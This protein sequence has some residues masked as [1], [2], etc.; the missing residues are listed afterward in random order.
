MGAPKVTVEVVRERLK[1][2]HGEQLSFDE[3]TFKG[4]AKPCLFIDHEYGEW[5]ALPSN[6]F[7]G[8]GHPMRGAKSVSQKIKKVRGL[9]LEELQK[10]LDK[11]QLDL[12]I[13]SE[14]FDGSNSKCCFVDPLYG[15]WWATP[16]NVIFRKTK[17]P[18]RAAENRKQACLVRYGVDNPTKN[19]N[20]ALKAAIGNN[21]TRK[22]CHWK[23]NKELICVA[24]YEIAVVHWLNENKIDFEWQP[25]PFQMPDARTYRPD[26]YI[27]DGMFANTFVEVKGYMR[28]DALEKW[29]WFHRGYSN[30]VLWTKKDLMKLG[31]LSGK[32]TN[33]RNNET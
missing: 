26:L 20:I 25:G 11:F 31:I 7:V 4:V 17:H 9:S 23:T 8:H 6:I 32:R 18:R 30:S 5:W 15:E 27:K 10:R 33:L 2:V 22:I 12:T 19:K 21:I 1:H 24:S 16:N 28:T 29:E 13:K 14:T 3:T